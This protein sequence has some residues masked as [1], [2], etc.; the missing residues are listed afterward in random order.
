M[1]YSLDFTPDFYLAE[2]EPYDRSTLALN[3]DGNPIS[4]YSAIILFIESDRESALRAANVPAQ[5]WKFVASNTLAETL[6]TQAQE[7]GTCGDI[8]SPVDVWLD[9]KGNYKVNVYEGPDVT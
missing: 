5:D 6:L 3:R 8:S 9:R 4:L 1:S 7:V 2:G